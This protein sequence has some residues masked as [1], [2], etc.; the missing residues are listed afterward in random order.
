MSVNLVRLQYQG[1]AVTFNEDGWFNATAVA[2]RFGKRPADWLALDSTREYVATLCDLLRS[3]KSSLLK[4]RRGGRG[5]P[6]ST[7]FHPKL[8]VPFARWLDVR[9][10][11]WCDIQIE[12]LLKGHHPHFDWKRLRHEASSTF[13][14]MNDILATV[15]ADQG[16]TTAAHHFTNEARLINWAL[17][18]EFK[19]LDRDALPAHDLD[20]LAKLELK[21]ATLIGRGVG[22]ADRKKI[23]E[24][25]ALESR[26]I[27]LPATGHPV[28]A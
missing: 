24:S 26:L 22:Y 20:L 21:N 8:A 12:G 1:V 23:L 14:V 15:R 6:D 4:V 10:A 25:T 18:G 28:A 2:D 3:E 17:S 27:H 19:G 9:F 5:K 13:K 11:I 7:W 16:K